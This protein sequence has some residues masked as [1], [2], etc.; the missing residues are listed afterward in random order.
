M[1][2]QPGVASVTRS[3]LGIWLVTLNNKWPALEEWAITM[4]QFRLFTSDYTAHLVSEDVVGAGTVTVRTVD[5]SG[6]L[7]D[8]AAGDG[9][10]IS[11]TLWVKNTTIDV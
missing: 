5:G 3:S 2:A 7:I 4:M 11:L 9:P 8:P 1:A 6:N 10:S